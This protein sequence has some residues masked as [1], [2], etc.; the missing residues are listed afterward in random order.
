MAEALP[1]QNLFRWT[2]GRRITVA[3]ATM[4]LVSTGLTGLAL[5]SIADATTYA[6]SAQQ[7]VV[8]ANFA[9]AVGTDFSRLRAEFLR[10]RKVEVPDVI[11]LH[12]SFRQDL[13]NAV[14]ALPSD[15]RPLL[16]DLR[17][18]EADWIRDAQKAEADGSVSATELTSLDMGAQ[19]VDAKVAELIEATSTAAEARRTT[20]KRLMARNGAAA[21]VATLAVVAVAILAGLA[22]LRGI[23]APLGR[24]TRFA[25]EIAQGRLDGATPKAGADELSHLIRVMDGMRE[26]ICGMLDE[27]VRLRQTSQARLAEA[28]D[29]S[30]EGMI[31]ADPQGVIQ[32]INAQALDL[33]GLSARNLSAGATLDTMRKLVGL[34]GH[35]HRAMLKEVEGA[36]EMQESLLPDGRRI[37]NSRHRTS[38]GGFVGLYTD[39]TAL[40]AQKETLTNAKATLDAALT[41]MSQALC[42]FDRDH[43]LRLANPQAHAL[44]GIG[45]DEAKPGSAY[46]ALIELSL[47]RNNH[48][49]TD[50]ARLRRHLR[51][52]AARRR[53]SV[54]FVP[55]GHDR[56]LSVTHEPMVD[57]GWMGTY[58]DVTERRRAAARI[59]HMATHDGLTG[60]P[61]RFALERRV[62]EELARIE[63]GGGF[64]ILCLG[65]DQFKEI[66]DTLGHAVGDALLCGVAARLGEGLRRTD[67]LVRLGSDEFAVV[68]S[69]TDDRDGA[70]AFAD[71][72]LARLKPSF[73]IDGRRLSIGGTGGLVLAPH[74]GATC[75]EL[76]TNVDLA[77]NKAKDG[78]ARGTCR[79]FE[80]VLKE[81]LKKRIRLEADLRRALEN[82]EFE[83][84]YQPL[85][86]LASTEVRAFEALMRWNHPTRGLV[87]PVEFIPVAERMGLIDAMGRWA[88]NVACREAAGW[89]ETVKVAVNVS[90]AQLREDSFAAAVEAALAASGLAPHRLE[91]ELTETIVMSNAG[92]A[93][94]GLLKLKH[95]GVR[96]AM[97]DFGTG[98][99]S[100]SYLRRFPF[101][102]I[103]IDRS[104]LQNLADSHEAEQIVR[105]IVALGRNLGLRV[106]AEGVE[107]PRQ[108]RFLTEIG[109]DEIQGYL[110]G[111]PE[112][113]AQVP[114]TLADH[115]GTAA[116][117]PVTA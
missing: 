84:F 14:G 96:F 81:A 101:N 29:G 25:N 87:G 41:T 94:E 110:I 74:H 86:D 23:K 1:Q 65:L 113:A 16:E 10:N 51:F 71:A 6:E 85:L 36:P 104:F 105:T 4:G 107:T 98:Y 95:L 61:T 82:D 37:Q 32:I 22:L 83:L 52:V 55:F 68:R 3:F 76:L 17:T 93:M 49:G 15:K 88:L 109:C 114:L 60:L 91:L 97:D 111:R 79:V 54:R 33:L 62:D 53:R 70:T 72:M 5:R 24:V 47:A 26:R 21:L 7:D 106:T 20:A 67:L 66:N 40:V 28:V 34:Y 69:G 78:E 30:R 108:L 112:P 57:G 100:L 43:R 27:Q 73:D 63:P 117:V 50:A 59:A 31:V 18:V 42:I 90:L 75:A 103:K 2:I 12:H 102:K 45:P 80:P 35:A 56:I 58:E 46:L 38:E 13:D 92:H 116:E 44:F 39:V 115:N 77:M 89:P 8:P 64:A 48:P 11:A 9:R 99:S 19:Q